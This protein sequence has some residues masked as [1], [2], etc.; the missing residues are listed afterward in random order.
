VLQLLNVQP[1]PDD[2][3]FAGFDRGLDLVPAAHLA[4]TEINNRS[5]ILAGF[6]LQV[7]DIDSEA[8]GRGTII[9]GLVNVYRE[10]VSQ[11][12]GSQCLVGVMGL[13]CSS[14]TNVLAPIIGH[15]NIGYVTL[16]NSVS[17]AH[18]NIEEYPNLFHTISSSSVHNI[19]LISLM[20][21]F[22]WNRIGVVYDSLSIFYRTTANDFVQR[23]KNI[24]IELSVN[25]PITTSGS[26]SEAFNIIN[27]EEARARVTYWLGNDD[28]NALCLCEAYQREFIYPGHVFIL[29]YNEKIM[30]N[31]LNA[32]TTCSMDQLLHAMDGVLL[33][34]YRLYVDDNTTLH[35]GWSY[36]EFRKRYANQLDEFASEIN[37]SLSINVYANSVYDQVWTYAL[38]LNN[39]IPLIQSKGLSLSDYTVGDTGPGAISS[40]IRHNLMNLSFQGASGWIE[41][42]KDNEIPSFVNIFQVI[43]GT[44]TL[45]AIYDP[46]MQNITF[47]MNI[48]ERIPSDTF[49]TIYILLPRWLVGSIFTAQVI[50][51]CL[52]TTNSLLLFLWRKEREV[53]ATS[54]VLSVLMM[55]G[56]YL[57]WGLPV[58]LMVSRTVVITN[59]TAHAFL[60]NFEAWLQIGPDFIFATLLLRML[61][62]QQIFRNKPM[63]EMSNYWKD[64]YLVIYILAIC[65]GKLIL[66]IILTAIH[67]SRPDSSIQYVA[68]THGLPYLAETVHCSSGA[69]QVWLITTLL[70]SGVL[71][72]M[73][74]LLAIMTR[75]IRNDV[76][77]DT[78]KVNVFIFSIT[79]LLPV[80]IIL[81][82]LSLESSIEIENR[83]GEW[84]ASF[85]ISMLCQV[86][87]FVPKLLPLAVKKLYIRYSHYC[88]ER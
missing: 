13:P 52:I 81:W 25:V 85:A 30:E 38:A 22:E 46:I 61:R 76:Y 37:E 70:Y 56:C 40:I 8:C 29:R 7:I 12:P 43:N 32:N 72:F 83:I 68:P 60:C 9:K 54:P 42:N 67:P 88:A 20:Q 23:A 19:V 66:L 84:L 55:I 87:I 27:S 11:A 4:A 39:S 28:Q 69:P 5:D 65:T 15:Q 24:E 47:L 26:V 21:N 51:F 45:I 50:L 1:Y 2:G 35:S 16:A 78:K 58:I 33:I 62:I 57:L 41:F 17:P 10:L 18:R 3:V 31:I 74:M 14:V 82:F 79:L 44:I 53:K 64:K 77:K 63:T 73:V 75:H 71:L 49:E 34:D 86:C 59:K 80:A 48:Q 36:N 6:D